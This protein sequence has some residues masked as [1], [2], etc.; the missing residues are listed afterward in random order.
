[1]D[2]DGTLVDADHPTFENVVDQLRKL[3]LLSIGF[4]IAT[5][6][7]IRGASIVTQ[8]LTDIGAHLPPMITYNGAVVLSAADSKIVTRYLIDRAAFEA[9]VRR[10]RELGIEALA[11]AC[12]QHFDFLPEETV[13]CEG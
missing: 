7:T 13:Y 10:C 12:Q 5:G 8:R 1:M 3:K 11:Y 9:V 6:R 4:S 2:I